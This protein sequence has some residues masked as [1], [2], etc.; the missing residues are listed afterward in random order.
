MKKFYTLLV[1]LFFAT[2]A[3]SQV[4]K[5][6]RIESMSGGVSHSSGNYLLFIDPRGYIQKT[7]M[8]I[9]DY[10]NLPDNLSATQRTNTEQQREIDELKRTISNLERKLNEMERDLYNQKRQIEDL[11]RKVR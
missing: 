1:F 11:Q 6:P 5:D 10:R 8:E 3:F 7:D 2:I 4:L 9:R